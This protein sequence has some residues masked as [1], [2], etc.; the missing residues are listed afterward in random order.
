MIGGGSVAG[1]LQYFQPAV[2]GRSLPLDHVR[3]NI[4]FGSAVAASNQRPPA[5]TKYFHREIKSL[6]R[7][8]P[9]RTSFRANPPAHRRS[10][11]Q[12]AQRSHESAIGPSDL[13]RRGAASQPLRHAQLPHF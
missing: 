4:H 11:V 3:R 7:P 2:F 5:S 10:V 6:R 12:L 13:A 1:T 8:T 9:P